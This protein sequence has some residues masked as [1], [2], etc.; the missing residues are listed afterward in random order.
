MLPSC[1][2]AVSLHKESFCR[3]VAVVVAHA[4]YLPSVECF[5]LLPIASTLARTGA[6]TGAA[7]DYDIDN[8]CV[9]LT[10]QRSVRYSCLNPIPYA[11]HVVVNTR[12][13]VPCLCRACAVLVP[14][15]CCGVPHRAV[16]C[17]VPCRVLCAVLC[18]AVPCC[19]V[20]CCA[21]PCRAVL[22]CAVLCFAVLC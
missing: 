18:C 3:A 21:M 15:H 12:C 8:A 2:V 11:M 7:L 6:E 1:A 13:A 16:C 19:A 5:A 14:Y 17:A 22:C 4:A 20:L 9:T 10:A